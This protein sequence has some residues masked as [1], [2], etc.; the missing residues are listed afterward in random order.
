MKPLAPVIAKVLPI[1]LGNCVAVVGS[2]ERS[3][4]FLRPTRANLAREVA[5]YH[6]VR[7]AVRRY[8]A[9]GQNQS[10]GHDGR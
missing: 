8:L 5:E 9:D 7:R 3:S 6:D 2:L 1:S 4:N 10:A